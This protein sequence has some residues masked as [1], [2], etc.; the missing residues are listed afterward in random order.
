[1]IDLT[2]LPARLD[3]FAEVAS[4]ME[5]V[6]AAVPGAADEKFGPGLV[7]GVGSGVRF[8]QWEQLAL[9]LLMLLIRKSSRYIW[10]HFVVLTR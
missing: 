2:P 8:L 9:A 6:V 1:M 4:P 7:V 5:S 10:S 3:R